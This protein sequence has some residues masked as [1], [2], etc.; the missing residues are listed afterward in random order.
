[1]GLCLSHL[2][3]VEGQVRH[4][5]V[6]PVKQE[7]IAKLKNGIQ[8]VRGILDQPLVWFA[9]CD[10]TW[11]VTSAFV[12]QGIRNLDDD[13]VPDEGVML[14]PSL[15]PLL[16]VRLKGL[17]L[18]SGR[19]NAD[20]IKSLVGRVQRSLKGLAKAAANEVTGLRHNIGAISELLNLQTQQV[21]F[22]SLEIAFREPDRDAILSRSGSEE[23]VNDAYSTMDRMRQLLDRGLSWTIQDSSED[24][25]TSEAAEFQSVLESVRQLAPTA[26]EDEVEISGRLVSRE[27]SRPIKLVKK[28][29]TKIVRTLKKLRQTKPQAIAVSGVIEE[30]DVGRCT[31]TVRS[32]LSTAEHRVR[33]R[34]AEEQTVRKAFND[35]VYVSVDGT[36]RLGSQI[37]D[38]ISLEEA[39]S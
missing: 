7:T 25:L 36:R 29:A 31:F 18:E 20:V 17:L 34:A 26:G 8:T 30:L 10:S 28:D 27:A 23:E 32:R 6:V 13:A 14:Y 15:E 2:V 21:A 3:S 24:T 35:E 33:Y 38:M 37:I 39:N 19:I 4:H 22:R 1:M 16:R 9:S 12:I 11:K 5:I